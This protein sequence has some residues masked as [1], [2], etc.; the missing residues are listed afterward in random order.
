MV[1]KYLTGMT[2]TECHMEAPIQFLKGLERLAV[3]MIRV[4][5]V[6]KQGMQT[7]SEDIFCHIFMESGYKIFAI[8]YPLS[9]KI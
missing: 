8:L 2:R 1:T 4:Q 6:G 7:S 5:T 9:F 3:Q